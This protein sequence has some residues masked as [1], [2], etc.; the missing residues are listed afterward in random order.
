MSSINDRLDNVPFDDDNALTD[1]EAEVQGDAVKDIET[2][3]ATTSG[4]GA[5][6]A[7]AETMAQQL[8]DEPVVVA[9]P[10]GSEDVEKGDTTETREGSQAAKPIARVEQSDTPLAP[11][12]RDVPDN[13]K[14]IRT[15]HSDVAETMRGKQVSL[16]DIALAEQ[17]RREEVAAA[18]PAG[19]RVTPSET[20]GST[21]KI[22]GSI[23]TIL[24]GVVLLGGAVGGVLFAYGAWI[25]NREPDT[26]IVTT[27]DVGI[28]V[29]H[30]ATIP[31]TDATNRNDIL[32]SFDAAVNEVGGSTGDVIGIQYIAGT[33][34]RMT[35]PP[36]LALLQV[37]AEDRL[38]RTIEDMF[39]AGVHLHDAE[40]AFLV[41]QTSLF[42][43]AFAG[44]LAWEATIIDDL[45]FL[46]NSL[47]APDPGIV[48]ASSET[49]T[50]TTTAT[51][52]PS[53]TQDPLLGA[54]FRDVV[55]DNKNARALYTARGEI[56]FIYSFP[57]TDTIVLASTVDTLREVFRRLAATRFSR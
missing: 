21:S 53:A 22:L 30:V 6:L 35:A 46:Q 5:F 41:L 45:P 25:A 26:I 2:A 15:Y 24:G 13:P 43:N 38:L 49:T 52:T 17:A 7:H 39:I 47:I 50:A 18:R 16:A 48:V 42:E 28:V 1:I 3:A 37:R 32:A 23:A 10:P 57:D 14:A 34:T 44:M 12:R 8:S 20:G 31:V 9:N 33:S 19:V 40:H 11:Q 54:A 55:I 29:E 56:A 27:P 4:E 36:F 51:T